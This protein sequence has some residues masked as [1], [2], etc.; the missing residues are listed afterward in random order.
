[1]NSEEKNCFIHH[2]YFWLNNPKSVEDRDQLI[3]GLRKLSK[4]GVIKKFHI[5]RPAGTL[6]DVID[7]TYS[8]SWCIY[9][10]NSADQQAYQVDPIHLRFVDDCSNLWSRVIVYDSVDA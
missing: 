10:A 5:G 6:R 4:V 2:V 9:F 3:A 8:I 7:I 1:M